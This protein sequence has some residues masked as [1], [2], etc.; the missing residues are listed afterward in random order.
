MYILTLDA[1][2]PTIQTGPGLESQSAAPHPGH[3]PIG[4]K[5]TAQISVGRSRMF[6]PHKSYSKRQKPGNLCCRSGVSRGLGQPLPELHRHGASQ[7]TSVSLS[8]FINK[9]GLSRRSLSSVDRKES[10]RRGNSRPQK[11]LAWEVVRGWFK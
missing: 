7:V 9:M 4:G 10:Q 5:S 3:A 8:F 1:S 11:W 2:F 6:S